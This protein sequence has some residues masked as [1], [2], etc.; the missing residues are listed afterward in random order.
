MTEKK[1]GFITKELFLATLA[2]PTRGWRQRHDTAPKPLSIA[3]ELRIEEGL[4][5]HARAR[6]LYSDGVM[7]GGSNQECIKQT[8]KLLSSASTRVIFEGT[9]VHGDFIAKADILIRH[10]SRWKL[11][12]V[13]SNVNDDPALVDDLAYTVF[14][15][16]GAGL[17]V[18]S[19]SLFLVSKEF[20]LGMIN[21]ELFVEIDHTDDA[22]I[23]A[24]EF[25]D[26]SIEIAEALSSAE[27]PI[28]LLQWECKGCEIFDTCVGEGIRNHIFELPRLSHTK[29]CQL[30]DM[31]I[32]SLE[33]I[34]NDF[35]LTELQ[36]RVREAVQTG[37]TFLDRDGLR[38][39]LGSIRCP[40]YWLDFETVQTCLPLFEGIAPYAQIPTQYSLHVCDEMGEIQEHREYLADPIRDCRRDLAEN[41]IQDCGRQ[42]SIVVYTAF[43]K[44]IIRALAR[45]FPDLEGGLEGLVGRLFDLYEVIRKHLYYPEFHGSFSIKR[46]LPVIVPYLNYTQMAIDNG[47]DASAMFAYLARGRYRGRQA[48]KVRRNLLEYCSLDTLAMVAIVQELRQM[49]EMM[50]EEEGGE[51]V[52]V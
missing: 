21:E 39:A 18:S 50:D 28:A 29:F 36:S 19:C 20:R 40:S 32:E 52:A 48:E 23:R 38:N 31:D 41:L 26:R 17:P 7:V 22:L 46:V 4:E 24:S 34:P 27:E 25:Q 6:T 8:Q 16:L 45:S 51:R 47:M 30:W 35:K 12:E 33:D 1:M 43:E 10:G 15:A 11:V 49:L 42:G 3:D 14:V 9:F 2:C 13:K 5:I 44:T 37:M